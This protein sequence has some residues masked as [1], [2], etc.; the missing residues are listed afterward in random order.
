MHALRLADTHTAVL[1]HDSHRYFPLHHNYEGVDLGHPYFKV[2]ATR[3]S[4]VQRWYHVVQLVDSLAVLRP[5]KRMLALAK[6]GD[7][8]YFADLNETLGIVLRR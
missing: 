8:Q 1:V 7:T 2:R 5:K 4:V 6:A 3:N